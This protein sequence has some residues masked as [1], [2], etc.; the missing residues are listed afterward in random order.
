M[1]NPYMI[2]ILYDSSTVL[3]I[4]DMNKY[5]KLLNAENTFCTISGKTTWTVSVLRVFN[6]YL[7]IFVSNTKM[8]WFSIISISTLF[9]LLQDG[10]IAFCLPKL[11]GPNESKCKKFKIRNYRFAVVQVKKVIL[12]SWQRGRFFSKPLGGRCLYPTHRATRYNCVPS[13][14][15]RPIV[16]HNFLLSFIL[17]FWFWF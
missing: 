1:F 12:V 9:I 17:K 13:I 10:E 15:S 5:D 11:S 3:Y 4:H 14:L 16:C 2:H 7:N 6:S 8:T